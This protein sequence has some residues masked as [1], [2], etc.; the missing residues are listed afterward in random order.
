MVSIV[1][2]TNRGQV[3]AGGDFNKSIFYLDGGNQLNLLE[4][5]PG[6]AGIAPNPGGINKILT[7][8]G[9]IDYDPTG[10]PV[11]GVPNPA[12]IDY[13]PNGTYLSLPGG[14][15]HTATITGIFPTSDFCT[16][17]DVVTFY[18][19]AGSGVTIKLPT[20]PSAKISEAMIGV[21]IIVK[22]VGG[23]NANTLVQPGTGKFNNNLSSYTIP[24]L[25]TAQTCVI[26]VWSGT[27]WIVYIN[28]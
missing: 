14:T 19:V 3:V 17:F 5:Q 20:F 6:R 27:S 2:F 11:S 1:P 15:A 21:P 16:K 25:P 23:W 28:S 13:R 26:F 22:T 8:S 18:E 7:P 4:F 12:R 10:L 24:K 9:W